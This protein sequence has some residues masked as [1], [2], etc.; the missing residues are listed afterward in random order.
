MVVHD[1][2]WETD[3]LNPVSIQHLPLFNKVV[4][5]STMH[6]I[7]SPCFHFRNPSSTA[8]RS[9]AMFFFRRMLTGS[10]LAALAR[11][12]PLLAWNSTLNFDKLAHYCSVLCLRRHLTA[13]QSTNG[14]TTASHNHVSNR[15][16]VFCCPPAVFSDRVCS[17][18]RLATCPHVCTSKRK[19]W[20][21]KCLIRN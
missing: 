3:L 4:S 14:R 20:R 21:K 16:S 2:S 15:D 1:V 9:F 18:F 6:R 19:V 10:L 7:I 17:V 8:L 13:M 12:P 11:S 5:K